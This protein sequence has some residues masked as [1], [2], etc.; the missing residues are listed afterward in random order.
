MIGKGI[1]KFVEYGLQFPF[2]PVGPPYPAIAPAFLLFDTIHFFHNRYDKLCVFFPSYFRLGGSKYFVFCAFFFMP[3]GVTSPSKILNC[4]FHF[5]I[6]AEPPGP[7][8]GDEDFMN[9]IDPTP[10]PSKMKKR[11]SLDFLCLTIYLTV[12]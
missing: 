3:N 12:E 2:V 6:K 10:T 11:G 1:I 4:K 8:P 7:L 5:L 9:I